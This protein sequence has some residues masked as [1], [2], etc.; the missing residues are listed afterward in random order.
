MEP[1]DEYPF[2]IDTIEKYVQAARGILY[3]KQ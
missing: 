2:D 1:Q 3:V